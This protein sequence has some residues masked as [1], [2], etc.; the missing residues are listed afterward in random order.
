MQLLRYEF[1]L[2]FLAMM[3]G[4]LSFSCSSETSGTDS[5]LGERDRGLVVLNQE[6]APGEVAR[7]HYYDFGDVSDGEV[8]SHTFKLW[9]SDRLPIMIEALEP[10]CGCTVPD[11]STEGPTGER[12]SGRPTDAPEILIV[13]P[14]GMVDLTVR[15]D[16]NSIRDKNKPKLMQV[17]IVTDSLNDPYLTLECS[18][19]V[20]LP[21][22]LVPA[23]IS[24]TEIPS[25]VGGGGR[26][27]IRPIAGATARVSHLG[28]IPAGFTAE[29][30]E[31][32]RNG[33]PYW[34]LD[35]AALPPLPAGRMRPMT[36]DVYTVDEAGE[37]LIVLPVRVMVNV[38][39]DIQ[40][41]PNRIVLRVGEPG[42]ELPEAVTE[43]K[44]NLD[45]LRVQITDTRITGSAKDWL[46]VS[47]EAVD[48]DS[49]GRSASWA[50][51]VGLK[52]DAEISMSSG[53]IQ[54]ILDDPNM[55]PMSMTYAIITS[56]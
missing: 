37:A 48:P 8:A 28:P 15:I 50:I 41:V 19:K 16:T 53:E 4:L 38:I 30:S 33:A 44:A 40:L 5:S 56:H 43:L 13:Q 9:N 24:L 7:P 52:S 46:Q 31:H 12:L 29:L 6:P 51:R 17:R 21:F 39:G 36:I 47:T 11:V 23:A 14:G 42:D 25:S 26:L 3:L 35:V 34:T 54:L 2:P 22:D 1:R 55:E 32:E 49:R 20:D 27:E 45:G 18:L 10:S